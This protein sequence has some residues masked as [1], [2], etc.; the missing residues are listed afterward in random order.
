MY[1]T[2]LKNYGIDVLP[3]EVEQPGAVLLSSFRKSQI[4]RSLESLFWRSWSS[5][6][7]SGKVLGCSKSVSMVSDR[8]GMSSDLRIVNLHSAEKAF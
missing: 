5:E 8:V 2:V 7:V 3:R 1:R 6:I 4:S